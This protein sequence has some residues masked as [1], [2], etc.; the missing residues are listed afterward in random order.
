[1]SRVAV[2][3]SEMSASNRPIVAVV[4]AVV[5]VAAFAAVGAVAADVGVSV[6]Q[7]EDGSATV[8][9]T[10]GNET[11]EN[12]TVDVTV[13]DEN[14]T[15]EGAGEYS[16]DENGTVDLPAP[17]ETVNVTITATVNESTANTTTQLSPA[18]DDPE[19]APFS[20][21]VQ[22]AGQ[23]VTV[24]VT[25]NGTGVDGAVVEIAANDTYTEE[26]WTH[27][28]GE[29]GTAVLSPPNETV[30]ATVTATKDNATASTTVTLRASNGTGPAHA[31]PGGFV[32]AFVHSLQADD[33]DAPLGH[34]I[35]SFVQGPPDHA[36][37]DGERG[38]PD[39]AGPPGN[40]TEQGPP[41]DDDRGPPGDDDRGPPDDDDRGPPGDDDDD[42]GDR[43][44]P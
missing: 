34:Y 16:T 12:A 21:G 27:V 28:T 3:P 41:D 20:I 35:S 23:H 25:E 2:D 8:T 13:D 6:D 22:Q 40:D 19:D 32:A 33:L 43:G 37:P 15:Y 7:A 39:H 42:D 10:E 1:M 38:P 26:E 4:V 11:V 29:D 17:E 14:A 30:E 31:P 18:D 44:P 9:V 5:L 36:G 24:A